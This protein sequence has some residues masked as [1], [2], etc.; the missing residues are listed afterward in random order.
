M[1]PIQL[2]FAFHG[3][4]NR[5]RLFLSLV[6]QLGAVTII[7]LPAIGAMALMGGLEHRGLQF[8]TQ[9]LLGLL[10]PAAW[11]AAFGRFKTASGA[12]MVSLVFRAVVSPLA[13]WCYL[14]G[15]VK[16]LHDR[17]RSGW[18]TIPFIVLPGLVAQFDDRI[19]DSVL[20]TVIDAAASVLFLW[21]MIEIWLLKG[22]RGPNRYGPD[23]LAEPADP[24]PRWD[25]QSELKFVSPSAG[26]PPGPHGK[27]SA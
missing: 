9:D 13:A 16:R 8:D 4:I 14:A 23:P 19:G 1:Q 25:Q 18:W 10:D 3:R 24:R 26:P 7:G 15:A 17:D 22:T 12:E 21:G 5:G 27:P 11:Q 2:L 6:L 20:A